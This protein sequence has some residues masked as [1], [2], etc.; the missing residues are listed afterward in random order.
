MVSTVSEEGH[1][2]DPEIGCHLGKLRKDPNKAARYV[3][4]NIQITLK[5]LHT[6]TATPQIFRFFRRLKGTQ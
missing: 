5:T 6:G 4:P 1:D 2:P 3:E